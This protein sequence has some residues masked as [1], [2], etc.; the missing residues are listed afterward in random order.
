MNV[1]SPWNV[2]STT[3]LLAVLLGGGCSSSGSADAT[4]EAVRTNEGAIQGGTVDTQHPFAVG[5]CG[6]IGGGSKGN[7][8]LFCSGA[9]IA[10]NLVVTARHCVTNSP[11]MIDCA[12]AKFGA[13]LD[14][15]AGFFVTTSSSMAQSTTGWHSV[16]KIVTPPGTQFCG[17]DLALLVLT[18]NVPASEA[19]PV[20]PV[21]Q[22]PMTDHDRYSSQQTAIGY[23]ITAPNTNTQGTRHI[24]QMINLACI[25]GDTSGLDCGPLGPRNMTE[26]EYEAGDGTC[27]G[28]S[29]SSAYEQVLFEK[30]T[31]SSFGVL[32]RGG[33]SADGTTCVGAVYTRLDKW[34]DLIVSTV[35]SAAATGGYPLPPWTVLV[36]PTPKGDA[37]PPP[38]PVDSGV[39]TSPT[40]GSMGQTC[41]VDG[42]CGSALCRAAPGIT[43]LTCTQ[44]CD[45]A[46]ACPSGYTCQGSFCFAHAEDPKP[47]PAA[48]PG[49]TT[50]TTSGCAMG[51]TSGVDSTRSVPGRW[52][53]LFAVV[54][55]AAV[56]R[57]RG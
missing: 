29:G 21:V 52:I 34:R 8:S 13:P 5:I 37:G 15:P 39:T 49:G 32:S 36:P 25:P 57:R 35:T 20:T 46:T 14:S 53:A 16:A 9:L 40:L 11:E 4:R 50:T 23:G 2:T 31:P 55:F 22:Y 44:A 43:A 26:N 17:N 1:F 19:T 18:G 56:R 12:T 45:A 41:G 3:A 51:A 10:P 27:S 54:G 42:D 33:V 7:C 6:T 24:R 28:D 38:P 48:A 30:G 47:K